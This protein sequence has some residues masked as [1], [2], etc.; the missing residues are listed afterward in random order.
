MKTKP[1]PAAPGARVYLE[2]VTQKIR[3]IT[4]GI[5]GTG[6]ETMLLALVDEI[7]QDWDIQ[8][9]DARPLKRYQ[10]IASRAAFATVNVHATNVIEA[11]VE[12][13]RQATMIDP[14]GWRL[15]PALDVALEESED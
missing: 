11:R 14:A 10:F 5:D 8:P 3:D 1:T 9:R 2:H 13:R 15:D 7:E 12:A 6:T 4:R